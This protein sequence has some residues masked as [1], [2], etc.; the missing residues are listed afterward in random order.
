MN[1]GEYYIVSAITDGEVFEGTNMSD[2]AEQLRALK[3]LLEDAI[4]QEELLKAKKRKF[5]AL[6]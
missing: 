3:Q 6:I 5:W 2:L 1:H 4:H